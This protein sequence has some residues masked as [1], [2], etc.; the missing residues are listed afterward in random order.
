MYP[1]PVIGYGLMRDAIE[2]EDGGEI[3]MHLLAGAN[4]NEQYGDLTPL[5]LAAHVGY[6]PGLNLLLAY[7]ADINLTNNKGETALF[8]AAAMGHLEAVEFLLS[9][10]ADVEPRTKRSPHLSALDIARQRGHLDIAAILAEEVEKIEATR[11]LP[12]EA[13]AKKQQWLRHIAGAR[14]RPKF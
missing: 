3:Q 5:M 13:I 6:A 4:T 9:R 14:L 2:N 12:H 1:V 7:Q 8:H 10:G 11:R